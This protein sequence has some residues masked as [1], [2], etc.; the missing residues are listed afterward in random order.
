MGATY[1]MVADSGIGLATVVAM[2]ALT[3]ALLPQSH[4]AT[5]SARFRQKP[6]ALY[7]VIAGPPDWRPEVSRWEELTAENGAKRVREYDRNGNAMTLEL[8]EDDPPR[9]RVGRIA[10]G[11]SFGGAWT[12]ELLP[13]EGGTQLRITER[14]EIYNVIFRF[15]AR[16]IIG[17]TGKPS[18]GWRLPRVDCRPDLL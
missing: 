10:P 1:E 12:Y 14:G 5:C 2:V 9:R 18:N 15:V 13:I 6:E 3:G 8:V 4:V 17:Y 7:A 11:G 16:F